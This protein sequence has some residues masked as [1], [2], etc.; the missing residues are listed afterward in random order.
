MVGDAAAL[1]CTVP[2]RTADGG[3]RRP[4]ILIIEDGK[5]LGR[6]L[7]QLL[8]NFGYSVTTVA[9]GQEGIDRY[10]EKPTDLVITDIF[11]PDLDGR[12]V[13]RKI[14]DEFPEARMIAMS[15]GGPDQAPLSEARNIGARRTF[16][17]PFDTQELLLVIKEELRGDDRAR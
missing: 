11:L 14:L 17:K 4:E 9:S 8:E 3:T 16:E 13:I 12:E 1:H 6:F 7:T 15:G 5:A 2:E 10:R